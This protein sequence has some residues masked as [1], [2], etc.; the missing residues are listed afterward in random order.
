M[1]SVV[2][3]VTVQRPQY[4]NEIRSINPVDEI[5]LKEEYAQ[6]KILRDGIYLMESARW[7]LPME[8]AR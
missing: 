1:E 2:T 4:N 6:G 5:C 3:V 8:F 7:N